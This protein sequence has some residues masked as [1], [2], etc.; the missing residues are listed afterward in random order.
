MADQNVVEDLDAEGSRLKVAVLGS[1]LIGLDLLAK[2]ERSKFLD[3]QLVVG[4]DENGRGLRKAASLGYQTSAGGATSLGADGQAFDIVFDATNAMSHVEHH[5]HLEALGA[6]VIDLT[7]SRIGH[8]IAPTVNGADAL[9]HRNVS[10]ISCGGQT[11]IPILHALTR[12]Y[13][14]SYIEVVTTAASLSVGRASRLN[15]DEYISTTQ[16]AVRTFTGA[17]DVKVMLNISPAQPPITFRVAISM[18]GDDFDV[19]VIR[20][21]VTTVAEEVRTFATG[22]DIAA[23]S[24]IDGKAFVAVEVKASGDLIPHYSGNLD[25]I[26][27]A[28][29]YVAEQYAAGR[30]PAE[31]P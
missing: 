25:I 13:S 6:L 15:L 30:A 19:D 14:P 5:Q 23:C 9:V 4:R 18:I 16:A 10:L 7:P 24:V 31:R 26:N 22:F 28:A 27:S 21:H 17:S 2:I 1:G 12:V 8:M 29:I 11:A 20:K 3:C